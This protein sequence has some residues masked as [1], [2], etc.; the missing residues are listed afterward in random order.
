MISFPLDI[1]KGVG[2]LDHMVALFLIVF[3]KPLSIFNSDY[4]NVH[5]YQQY[6]SLPFSSSLQQHVSLFSLMVAILSSVKWY[7]IEVLICIPWIINDIEH[8]FTF[9]HLYLFFGKMSI[10]VLVHILIVL[11]FFSL[12]LYEFLIYFVYY[13]W[14]RYMASK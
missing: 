7:F 5:S 6:K 8:I 4:T 2:L 3:E 12:E 14:M 11:F 13:C 9:G 10:Q 1:Y